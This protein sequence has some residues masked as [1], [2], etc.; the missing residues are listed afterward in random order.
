MNCPIILVGTKND[1]HGARQI[2]KQEIN[3]LIESHTP[4][5]NI[6]YVETS[7]KNGN[8]IGEVFSKMGQE[9]LKIKTVV[10]ANMQKNIQINPIIMDDQSKEQSCCS[11]L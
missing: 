10:P 7:A 9:L 11:I 8:G 3:V 5:V 4:K 6:Q 2:K 1:K